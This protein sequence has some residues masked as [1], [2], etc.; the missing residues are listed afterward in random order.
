MASTVVAAFYKF[1]A[2]PNHA[3]L[4]APIESY[5]RSHGVEG[6][7]LLADEGINATVAGPRQSIDS[8]LGFLRQQPEFYDLEHKE[9]L[10]EH[11]PFHRLKVRL[12]NEIVTIGD[13]SVSPTAVVGTYVDPQDWNALLADPDV[14][15]ID[16]RNSYETRLG[17]FAG[18]VDPHINNFTDFPNWVKQNL[19]PTQHRK[20]AMFCTGGIRCEKASSLLLRDGFA[21]VFH[22]KGGILKYLEDVPPEQ[23]EWNG[24]CF[25][26]DQRVSVDQ[27]LQPGSYKLCYGCQEPVSAQDVQ[28]NEFEQGVCCPRCIAGLA[29]GVIARRR[30]RARQVELAQTRG[31]R[32]IGDGALPKRP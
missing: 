26:F 31:Q 12:K 25:V 23:S 2:L 6:N 7:V 28:S 1:V 4:Q 16:T 22:L 30:E 32:H 20:V 17:T 18:A 27:S 21:Q 15:L 9:S 3:Q 10:C 24:E 11:P 13:K 8:F 19:D 14:I 29:E 5:C